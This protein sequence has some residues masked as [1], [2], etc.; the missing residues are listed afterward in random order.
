MKLSTTCL[1]IT[2]LE[3]VSLSKIVSENMGVSSDKPRN[4]P[5]SDVAVE[6]FRL[7]VGQGHRVILDKRKV[8]LEGDLMAKAKRQLVL[9]TIFT[10]CTERSGVQAPGIN[11]GEA[12]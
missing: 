2:I 8:G 9:P 6:A 5:L 3:V 12:G 7:G 10:I 4:S 1:T 11:C